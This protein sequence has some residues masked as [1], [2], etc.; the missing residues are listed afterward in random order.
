MTNSLPLTSSITQL[1][2]E[3]KQHYQ[4]EPK[5]QQLFENCFVNTYQTTIRPQPDGTTFVITGDIPAMWLRDSAAQVRPYL[6]LANEDPVI[7]DMI[8]GVIKRQFSFIDH[9]PYANAFN[10][11]ANGNR[12]HE[13]QTKMTDWI[14]ERKYEI[15]SLCYPIQL[16]YLYWKATGDTEHFNDT[17]QQAVQKILQV[18]KTEQRHHEDSDYHFVRDNCPAQD[19]LS[20]DGAGAPVEYTG[21]TW[22]GFRPSDDACKYGYLVPAN[23][24]AVVSLQQL[25]EIATEVLRDVE[26]AAKAEKLAQEIDQGI[27][28]YGTIDHPTYGQIYVYE[29]DGLGNHVLMDDANVPSLLSMPYLGYCPFDDKIYQNTRKFLLSEDNPYYFSG[30]AASGI[31]SPHTPDQYI[32]HIALAIQGLTSIEEEE[33]QRITGLFQTTDADENLMHEG[34]HVD[35]PTQYTRPWFSWANSMFSE[36]LL[37]RM[38]RIVTGSPLEKWA[39]QNK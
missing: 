2:E 5:L 18:W 1:I 24:F 27:K 17:F 39:A 15:D 8:K 13:D 33:K 26:L 21:M 9:D 32:W 12:Y 22:S 35:D 10:E 25:S 30:K 3:V 28:E 34:F 7:A 16:A 23:M 6:M 14:W 4:T 31:G 29:T 38:G 36:F 11:E 20:H 37:S 19:T